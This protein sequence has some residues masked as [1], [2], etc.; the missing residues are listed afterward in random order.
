MDLINLSSVV[1]GMDN[2][3]TL[4][5]MGDH[6]MTATGD[7][8]GDTDD[9]TN[10]LLFAYSK[11]HKFFTSSDSG[12]DSEMLQQVNEIRQRSVLSI[13]FPRHVTSC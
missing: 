4:L 6:G 5:I 11:Q 3:T 1:A 9:E 12:S 13:I 2:E 10:A 7:H 8:G